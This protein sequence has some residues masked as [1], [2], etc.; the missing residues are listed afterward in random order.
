MTQAP[1]KV[2]PLSLGSGVVLL[3]LP[4]R[5]PLLLV[6][7]IEGYTRQGRPTLR[8][9]RAL[10]VNEPFV[11]TDLP[12]PPVLPR[13]LLLEGMVQAAGALQVFVA[14]QRDLEAL[15]R[16][17]DELIK[18]LRN[19]DIGYRLEPGYTPGLGEDILGA[20]IAA[21]HA[22]V[23]ALGASQ[24]KF[25]RNAF[26]GDVLEYEL[27]LVREAGD[28]QHFEAEVSVREKLVAQGMLSLSRVEAI[29]R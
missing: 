15:G 14:V 12:L 17:A 4:H 8:A 11:S 22:R 28:A 2:D 25:V 21:G 5:P 24:V 7:R 26:P 3:L 6:D 13:S 10:S 9:S 20:I 1:P 19:A 29:L 16:S 27:R 18:A 23:G